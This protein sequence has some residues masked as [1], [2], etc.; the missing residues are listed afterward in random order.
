MLAAVLVNVFLL[1]PG[2][3]GPKLMANQR[4]Q[5]PGRRHCDVGI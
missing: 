5:H 3:P 4:S 2:K 1:R